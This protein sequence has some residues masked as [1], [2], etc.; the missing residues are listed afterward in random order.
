MPV[1]GR[2]VYTTA[3]LRFT[4]RF[5]DVPGVR[6]LEPGVKINNLFN[7][8][9]ESTGALFFGIPTWTSAAGRNALFTI[10]VTL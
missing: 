1:T 7:E 6:M 4:W 2:Y 8:K 10:K 3:N 5:A 9:Y